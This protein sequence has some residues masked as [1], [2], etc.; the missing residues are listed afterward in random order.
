MASTVLSGN[1]LSAP[2]QSVQQK[3]VYL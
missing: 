1:S 2:L 3:T